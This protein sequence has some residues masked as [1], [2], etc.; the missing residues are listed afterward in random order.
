LNKLFFSAVSPLSFVL[1]SRRLQKDVSAC[2]GQGCAWRKATEVH[3]APEV[4][5]RWAELD[6][7]GV[8][9]GLQIARQLRLHTKFAAVARGSHK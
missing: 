7:R 4:N 1:L 6:L 5:E 8:A 3:V 9:R 2:F